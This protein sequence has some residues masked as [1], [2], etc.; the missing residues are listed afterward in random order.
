MPVGHGF[1]APAERRYKQL[2]YAEGLK[3]PH[4]LRQGG[5]LGLFGIGPGIENHGGAG[6]FSGAGG[7]FSQRQHR[8]MPLVQPVEAPQ[9]QAPPARRKQG[10]FNPENL[11]FF[12]KRL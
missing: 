9:S 6:N 10:A 11:H 1:Q 5:D 12:S 2:V 8:K 7:L 4:L 3:E